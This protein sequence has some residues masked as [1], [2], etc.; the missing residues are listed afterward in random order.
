MWQSAR[1]RAGA[2]GVDHPGKERTPHSPERTSDSADR[3]TRGR[4]STDA[5]RPKTARQGS[6]TGLGGVRPSSAAP[7]FALRSWRTT[8]I[9]RILDARAPLD[10]AQP[11]IRQ[12]RARW[13]D[14]D[15]PFGD[16][17]DIVQV[18]AR[19]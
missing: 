19:P 7:S 3:M 18:T 2:P 11:E 5:G 6:K 10:P 8:R 9:R 17:S 4:P 15:Q 14:D 12:Y 16:R 1:A 13:R